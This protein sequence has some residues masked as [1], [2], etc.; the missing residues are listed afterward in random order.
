MLFNSWYLLLRS[1]IMSKTVTLE[2]VQNDYNAGKFLEVV[3]ASKVL[4]EKAPNLL[5]C[6]I[7]LASSLVEVRQPEEAVKVFLR[8]LKNY[9]Q[10]P[11]TVY[12]NLSSAY[13]NLYMHKDS[14]FYARQY[15]N[16]NPTAI[17][18]YLRLGE[19]YAELA[20]SGERRMSFFMAL[21]IDPE[22]QVALRGMSES[23]RTQ[24]DSEGALKYL[25]KQTKTPRRDMNILE[26]YYTLGH[27]LKFN[28]FLL[29]LNKDEVL[30]PLVA[31]LSTHSSI[32]FSQKDNY[33]FCPDPLGYIQHL[34]LGESELKKSFI[35]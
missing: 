33:D 8:I 18:G 29:E 34:P 14:V 11:S 19:L 21:G 7:L 5:N 15:V 25:L 32:R 23:F 16:L 22:N 28:N 27:K 20:L 24:S 26:S 13:K 30:L 1:F 35:E 17:L 4:L 10:F 3:H 2:S 9:K 12:Y 6:E 31:C